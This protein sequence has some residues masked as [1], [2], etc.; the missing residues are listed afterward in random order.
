MEVH[1]PEIDVLAE[2]LKSLHIQAEIAL[3]REKML[4]EQRKAAQYQAKSTLKRLSAL[5]EAQS[6]RNRQIRELYEA[7]ALGE[8]GKE[9]YLAQKAALS[10]QNEKCSAQ[11]ADLQAALDA[12][13]ETTEGTFIA[14]FKR[15]S[16]AEEVSEE[17]IRELLKEVIVY[18]HGRLEVVW[19]YRDTF[20][21]A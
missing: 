14:N 17:I 10:A 2:I 1:I 19:N 5:Q 21:T 8:V 4:S 6:L 16:G 7:F 9:E 3:D 20:I 11:I 15:F 18:P 12:K 13:D